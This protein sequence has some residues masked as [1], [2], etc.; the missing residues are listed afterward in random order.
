MLTPQDGNTINGRVLDCNKPKGIKAD[1]THVKLTY[2]AWHHA[3]SWHQVVIEALQATVQGVGDSALVVVE[4]SVHGLR[5][6]RTPWRLLD[7]EEEGRRYLNISC[8]YPIFV[9]LLYC[10]VHSDDVQKPL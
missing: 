10:S 5:S 9:L 8:F 6:K 2:R 3:L 4:G 7:E 1:K